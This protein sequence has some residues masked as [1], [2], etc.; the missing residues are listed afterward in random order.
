MRLGFALRTALACTIVDCT[1]LYGPP[2]LKKVHNLPVHFVHDHN[3]NSPGRNA[4]GR[5]EKLLACD[6]CH[7][8][9]T[10]VFCADPLA[11][12]A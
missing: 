4:L 3:P 10:V 8:T 12:G 6:L 2:Q 1:V 11:G 5:H 7:G 9:G